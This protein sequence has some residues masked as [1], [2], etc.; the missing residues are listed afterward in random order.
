LAT[1]RASGHKNVAPNITP[2]F[3]LFNRDDIEIG[4]GTVRI[5]SSGINGEGELREQPANPGSPGKMAVKTAGVCM[6]WWCIFLS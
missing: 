6:F 2:L 5:H 1:G 3:K 4:Q